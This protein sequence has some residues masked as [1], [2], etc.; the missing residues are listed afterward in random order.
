MKYTEKIL[1]HPGFQCIQKEITEWERERIYCH[2]EMSHALD[3]CRM[4][5]ILY[6]ELCAEHQWEEIRTEEIKDRIYVTG[7]LHDIGRA[8]QYETGEHHS[9]AG[10]KIAE[11]ILTEIDFPR[12][13]KNDVLDTITAHHGR[14]NRG[15]QKGGVGFLAE[16]VTGLETAELITYCIQRADH[17]S[18]NCFCCEAAETCKWKEEERNQTVVC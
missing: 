18:R 17:L 15:S 3:V 10:E 4:A 8:A 2:H 13:W 11:Q 1:E 14:N 5:W 16:Q 7:L 6:L 12:E 9:S